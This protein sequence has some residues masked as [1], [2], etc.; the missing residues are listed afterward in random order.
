MQLGVDNPT[1]L[2]A[3]QCALAYL[4]IKSFIALATLVWK[5]L[6]SSSLNIKQKYGGHWALVTGST[7]GIGKAYAFALAKC[8]L[9]V[10]LVSRT[11][12]KLDSVAAEIV[13]KYPK[14]KSKS[15]KVRK[16]QKLGLF[17]RFY[18]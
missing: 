6:F 13:E 2:I 18:Y 11:Q 5:R 17:V 10:I 4:G 15:C 7:D 8:N 12:S 3:G 1:I 16:T 9:N 14:G